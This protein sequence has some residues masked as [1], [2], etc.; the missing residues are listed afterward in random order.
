MLLDLFVLPN[1][2]FRAAV[3]GEVLECQQQVTLE[4]FKNI[5]S[6]N[7]IQESL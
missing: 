1:K 4:L 2:G 7:Q 5:F 3:P 6:Q